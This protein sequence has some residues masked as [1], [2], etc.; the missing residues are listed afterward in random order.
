MRIKIKGIVLLTEVVSS[1]SINK[2]DYLPAIMLKG[3]LF[4]RL[5]L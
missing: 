2:L 5:I 1:L 3:W 4:V